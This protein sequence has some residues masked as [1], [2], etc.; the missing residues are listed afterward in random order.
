LTWC[1]PA[2]P[3]RPIIA[4]NQP[5]PGGLQVAQ[6]AVFGGVTGLLGR[7]LARLRTDGLPDGARFKEFH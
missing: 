6:G 3:G 5:Q 1:A 2:A 7:D 4:F